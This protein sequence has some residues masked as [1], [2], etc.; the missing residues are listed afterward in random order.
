MSKLWGYV[1]G[2]S[3]GVA[4]P[5]ALC[6]GVLAYSMLLRVALIDA[7]LPYCQ[8]V[9]EHTWTERAI[10]MLKTGDLNP[11][12]FTKPSVMVYL[13]TAGLSLGVIKAGMAGHHIANAG[14]WENGGYPFY[15]MPEAVRVPRLLFAGFSIAAM[16]VTALIVCRIYRQWLTVQLP[17]ATPTAVR[18]RLAWAAFA[19]LLLLASSPEFLR[20]S[21][22]YINVD[23]IGCFF[24]LCT[25][26]YVLHRPKS[27][28]PGVVAVITG[29]LVGLCLGSKYNLYPIFLPALLMVALDY[30]RQW[31][32][33]TLL[34]VLTACLTFLITTP[35]A[36]LDLPSFTWA[37]AKQAKHYSTVVKAVHYKPGWETFYQYG[38]VV[39][40]SFSPLV[41]VLAGV[42]V[43]VAARIDARQ[44]LLALAFPVVFWIYMS[45]QTVFFGRNLV[46]LQAYVAIY[47]TLGAAWLVQRSREWKWVRRDL[48]GRVPGRQALLVAV[49]LVVVAS[50]PLTSVAKAL[51][52]EVESR[53]TVAK[54]LKQELPRGSVILVAEELEFDTRPFAK[55]FKVKK[56][57]AAKRELR[58]MQKRYPGAVALVPEFRRGPRRG[59]LSSNQGTVLARY[60][61]H[62]VRVRAS[63]FGETLAHNPSG[64][65]KLS[66]IRLPGKSGN[67][68]VT[69]A[70]ARD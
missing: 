12:R 46:V 68:A 40:G 13:T 44:T 9:D 30:R 51:D 5:V 27:S 64:N 23:I 34:I 4:L 43:V 18:A 65:P 67:T 49:A 17:N 28:S 32:S 16:C 3:W 10:V 50:T 60:G 2:L 48:F 61:Y 14:R 70:P 39:F 21:W 47:A 56:Y 29:V 54:W 58:R 57:K 25:V 11:H 55:R 37:A 22:H 36:L 26:A 33:S 31:L 59:G 8:H 52:L 69:M 62:P 45:R 7:S 41:G 38:K 53:T 19:T 6:L 24:L 15:T 20:L 63:R 35:Y 66:V 42:G 1:R